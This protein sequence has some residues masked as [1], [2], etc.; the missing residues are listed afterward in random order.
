MPRRTGPL[1]TSSSIFNLAVMS[2]VTYVLLVSV[3][4]GLESRF[5]PEVLGLVLSRALGII[6]FEFVIIKLGCYLL[7]IIGEHTMVDLLAYSGYKFVGVILTLL[8]GLLRMGRLSYWSVWAYTTAANAFFL[9]SG[10]RRS[11]QI[12]SIN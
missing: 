4:R 11:L 2:V 8:M 5:H 7:N 12:N 10:A 3:I 1:L 9:V 6:V